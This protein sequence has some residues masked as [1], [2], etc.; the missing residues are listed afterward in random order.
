M[1]QTFSAVSCLWFKAWKRSG[2]V[3]RT[4]I[5][6]MPSFTGTS[7]SPSSGPTY[8]KS[9][10]RKFSVG[11]ALQHRHHQ[12]YPKLILTRSS[13][14]TPFWRPLEFTSAGWSTRPGLWQ[15]YRADKLWCKY[16]K[17]MNKIYLTNTFTVQ[18]FHCLQKFLSLFPSSILVCLQVIISL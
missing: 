6:T 9:V 18:L 13:G 10:Q 5:P 7:R 3:R 16:Q 11:I 14:V 4:W 1:A 15:S 12:R 2:G 17:E 8:W